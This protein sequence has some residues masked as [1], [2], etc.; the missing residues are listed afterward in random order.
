MENGYYP[1]GA[2]NDSRAPFN[3]EE[4]E[5]KEIDVTI[6]ISLSKTFKLKV[7]DYNILDAGKD[8]DGNFYEHIDYSGCNLY[9]AVKEQIVL[10]NE[11]GSLL[12]NLDEEPLDITE[13]MDNIIEDISGWNLDDY[14]IIQE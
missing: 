14:E 4:L 12:S 2:Q 11:A 8:E 6:C 13:K 5:E 1:I 7:S 10:P 3:E 9:E